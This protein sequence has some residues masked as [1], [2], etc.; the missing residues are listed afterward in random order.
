MSNFWGAHQ[1]QLLAHIHRPPSALNDG[2]PCANLAE[3]EKGSPQVIIG[4]VGICERQAEGIVV[5]ALQDRAAAAD[6]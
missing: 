5:R 6:Y 3:N 2:S 1:F 4:N